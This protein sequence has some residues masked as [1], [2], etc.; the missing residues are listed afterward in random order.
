M[1]NS[2]K[3]NENDM[4]NQLGALPPA[5]GRVTIGQYFKRNVINE[6]SQLAIYV[7]IGEGSPDVAGDLVTE[8]V[9]GVVEVVQACVTGE[10]VPVTKCARILT[11]AVLDGVTYT[12]TCSK[13]TWFGGAS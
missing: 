13:M 9:R 12:T 4:S 10:Y 3:I 11:S 5:W 1:S 2:L 8:D 7:K 6:G